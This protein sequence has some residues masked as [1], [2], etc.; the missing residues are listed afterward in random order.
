M[1][2]FCPKAIMK[3]SLLCILVN[4]TFGSLAFFCQMV[5]GEGHE[6]AGANGSIIV[7]TSSEQK[8]L[9]HDATVLEHVIAAF[10]FY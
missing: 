9:M 1:S 5:T 2:H 10:S 8:C 4:S 6:I 7:Y 3:L